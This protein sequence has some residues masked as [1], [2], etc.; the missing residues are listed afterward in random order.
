MPS[1]SVDPQGLSNLRFV[2]WRIRRILGA[3]DFVDL[4]TEMPVKGTLCVDIPGV[5]LMRNLSGRYIIHEAIGLEQH[6]PAFRAPPQDPPLQSLSFRGTVEDPSR[7][8]LAR[9]FTLVLPRDPD[10]AHPDAE[11]SLFRPVR[12]PLYPA[13]A[14]PPPPFRWSLVRVSLDRLVGG[15]SMPLSGA[16]VRITDSSGAVLLASGMTDARGE[17]LVLVPGIPFARS[18]DGGANGN[19]GGHEDDSEEPV[20]VYETSV[21]LQIVWNA[22]V[23]GFPDPERL[24]RERASFLRSDDAL[25]LKAGRTERIRKT[26]STT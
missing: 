5:R 8:Y 1:T 23:E 22:D 12:V 18:S 26:V 24:E 13:P 3:V 17:G 11:P 14:A 7:R 6:G 20:L 16:L 9:S 25:S 19:G 2:E 10:P 4:T 21:R 15:R